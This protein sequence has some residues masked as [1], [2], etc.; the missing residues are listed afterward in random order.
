VRALAVGFKVSMVS[1]TDPVGS[2]PVVRFIT[3][4]LLHETF[5]LSQQFL[6]L[7]LQLFT[8][9]LKLQLLLL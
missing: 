5:N 6:L 2:C 4:L 9:L 8:I 3:L 1:V 7:F